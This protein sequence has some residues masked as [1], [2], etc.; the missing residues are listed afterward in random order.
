MAYNDCPRQVPAT[1]HNRRLTGN[2]KLAVVMVTGR[3]CQ[4]HYIMYSMLLTRKLT[5]KRFDEKQEVTTLRC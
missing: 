1:T 4:A 5:S 2:L 3:G